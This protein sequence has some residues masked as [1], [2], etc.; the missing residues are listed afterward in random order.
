[1][2][3]L[4]KVNISVVKSVPLLGRQSEHKKVGLIVR[5]LLATVKR[6]SFE[7]LGLLSWAVITKGQQLLILLSLSKR[8]WRIGLPV[9]TPFVYDSDQIWHPSVSRLTWLL[10]WSLLK[11]DSCLYIFLNYYCCQRNVMET[12]GYVDFHHKSNQRHRSVPSKYS[13]AGR[14]DAA[15]NVSNSKNQGNNSSK[16]TGNNRCT[17]IKTGKQFY[18]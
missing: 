17:G 6:S 15:K 7:H 14:H 9:V 11:H 12:H 4:W 1:M 5:W 18:R 13:L 3:M 16:H 8:F 2:N 10:L